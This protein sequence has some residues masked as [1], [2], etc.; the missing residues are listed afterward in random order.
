MSTGIAGRPA[1]ELR[2]DTWLA[3]TDG[4]LKL[5]DIEA[6]VIYLYCFQSWCP[7]CHSH[8][9][10]T[11]NEIR[12]EL[13]ARGLGDDVAFIAVQTVFEGHDANN[14]EA[15]VDSLARHGLDDIPLGHDSGHPPTIMSDYQTGGTPW[16]ILIGPDR[17]VMADGF[18]IDADAAVE[19]MSAVI[20]AHRESANGESQN[21]NSKETPMST[22][23]NTSDNIRRFDRDELRDRL[24]AEQFEVTQNGGTERPYTGIYASNKDDGTYN[25][26]VCEEALFD[27]DAKFE[28]GSGWPSFHSAVD[29]SKVRRIEDRSLG[30][31]RVE[32]RCATC[33]AHLGHVFP[34]GPLPSGER[35]CMN[36]ASLDLEQADK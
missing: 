25:C 4:D 23:T 18:R 17:R 33:D 7:G 13:G 8:G 2:V 16:T 12:R 34:D 6:P 31:L 11:M 24:T 5:A 27:S 1:P 3:N 35:F 22:D 14:A 36:S 26:I 19:A 9:F 20:E 30:M 29:P 32:A 28:S 10:P 21:E 15:A